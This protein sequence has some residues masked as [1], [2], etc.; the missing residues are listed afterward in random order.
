LED[1]CCLD[2]NDLQSIFN[3]WKSWVESL[4]LSGTVGVDANTPSEQGFFRTW[5]LHSSCGLWGF[6]DPLPAVNSSPY[7]IYLRN[8][9]VL[10]TCYQLDTSGLADQLL[11]APG[12]TIT[13]CLIFRAQVPEC[14]DLG[15]CYEIEGI[16]IGP[17]F[18]YKITNVRLCTAPDAVVDE[19]TLDACVSCISNGTPPPTPDTCCI[20]D[21]CCLDCDEWWAIFE[22]FKA[23]VEGYIVPGVLG[24]ATTLPVYGAPGGNILQ[25]VN[26]PACPVYSF[27]EDGEIRKNGAP[28]SDG[29]GCSFQY[30][31][32]NYLAVPI[33]LGGSVVQ[34]FLL[35]SYGATCGTQLTY[36]VGICFETIAVYENIG[37]IDTWRNQ[38][39]NARLCAT[40]TNV[41]TSQ[42]LNDCIDCET[43]DVDC[44]GITGTLKFI[45]TTIV[46]NTPTP[47]AISFIGDQPPACCG[48]LYA[49]FTG[50]TADPGNSGVLNVVGSPFQP[51]SNMTGL[52]FEGTNTSDQFTLSFDVISDNCDVVSRSILITIS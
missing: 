39:T 35:F 27:H 4:T 16:Q 50:Y 1:T 43:G 10:Q 49:L 14:E 30:N 38:I 19:A 28:F 37:G 45:P 32:S 5:A 12:I 31:V 23:K 21:T 11:P 8:G 7:A 20:P 33:P 3:C 36:P 41:T 44:P 17:N 22:C 47:M 18:K 6:G 2:C 13:Q 29:A 26:T 42:D 51:I 9:E 46:A 25:D 52:T 34:C 48:D 15:Y 40:P 24:S